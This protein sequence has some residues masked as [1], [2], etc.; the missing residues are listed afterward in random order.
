MPLT[1]A[2]GCITIS[3]KFSVHRPASKLALI[4]SVIFFVS[5]GSKRRIYSSSSIIFCLD[6]DVKRPV[7][8][9]ANSRPKQHE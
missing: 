9:Y 8:N 1:K 6:F 3:L 5:S 4:D 7:T 2:D